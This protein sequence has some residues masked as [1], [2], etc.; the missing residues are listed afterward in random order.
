MKDIETFNQMSKQEKLV[1]W[2]ANG[3]QQIEYFK[4]TW[5]SGMFIKFTVLKTIGCFAIIILLSEVETET[6]NSDE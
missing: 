4:E 5:M 2:F 3:F 6:P 1:E